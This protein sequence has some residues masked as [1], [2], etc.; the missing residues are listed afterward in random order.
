MVV[1]FIIGYI[2]GSLFMAVFEVAM[3]TVFLCFLIDE[4]LHAG[5]GTMC[6]SK[7]LRALVDSDEIKMENK[8][9]AEKE[10]NVQERRMKQLGLADEHS[11]SGTTNNTG[12]VLAP[13]V[14]PNV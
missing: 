13:S 12:V 9:Y 4:K 8:A 14:Q 2:V 6:A 1:I 11:H 7:G 10:H 5:S 3:D